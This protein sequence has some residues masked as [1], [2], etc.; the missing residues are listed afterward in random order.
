MELVLFV[1]V[2]FIIGAFVVFAY[3]RIQDQNTKKSAHSE[4]EK[5]INKAKS[6]SLKIKKDSE[7]KAKDF[8]VKARKTIETE[9]NK[10]K[11]TLKNKETQLERR[12]KEIED[13]N[14]N[15]QDENDRFANQLKDR[16]EKTSIAESRL[17]EAEKATQEQIQFLQKKLENI[18][19]MSQEQAKRE[20]FQVLEETAK[21]EASKRIAEIEEEAIK[22]SDKKSRNI[23]ARAMARFASEYTSERTVSV[24]SLTSDE[25][26]GKIIGREGRNIRTLESMCGVDLIVD[27]TPETIVISGFDPIRRE[28]A[29]RTIDKLMEDGRVHPAR[30][31]EVVEKQKAELTKSMKE[32]GDK[33]IAELGIG[34][35][36]G[37]LTKMVGSLKYRSTH[38]QNALNHSLE[39]AHISGLL[40]A[41]IGANVKVAKRAGLLH[42]IGL[43]ADHTFEGNHAY[44][45]AD[46]AK[47]YGESEEVVNAIRCHHEDEKPASSIAWIVHAANVLSNARP[48]ARRNQMDNFINRLKDLES[49][50]NSFDG[51]IK[52]VALQ[53]GREVRVLVE[54]SR[55]TD[56]QSMM[57]ARDIV[58]KIEREMAYAGQVKVTVV[59]ESRSVEMA[60]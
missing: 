44:V 8:E 42:D 45:G 43:A 16:E 22:E 7:T 28:L 6:E 38:A 40:A 12:L 56:D 55:V 20:L 15:K 4:A 39:V 52:A 17:K 59:R 13:Q 5:I 24:M 18:A 10:Q 60:R 19:Q 25:M 27:D 54:S 11:V 2:G 53:A 49:I 37:E 35:L 47:K 50:A 57:L 36:H 58:K 23:L 51:V 1:L 3:K 29:R 9:I 21:V 34:S 32:E 30:I 33:V 41:E 48:G 26:K 31:E 14:K 46:L